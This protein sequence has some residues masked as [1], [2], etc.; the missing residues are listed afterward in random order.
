MNQIRKKFLDTIRW[1]ISDSNQ[2]WIAYL[3]EMVP[4]QRVFDIII[5]NRV[6]CVAAKIKHLVWIE[7]RIAPDDPKVLHVETDIE[8][9]IESLKDNALYSLEKGFL[10]IRAAEM[11]H[12]VGL[13]LYYDL[14]YKWE[15]IC[16]EDENV[17][18]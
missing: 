6:I 14:K 4:I 5:D 15:R 12:R 7:Q 8:R 11:Y 1:M 10:G 3:G 13:I 17:T 16:A 18:K 2:D 9:I